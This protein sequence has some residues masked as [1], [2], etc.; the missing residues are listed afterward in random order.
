MASLRHTIA[1]VCWGH[2]E[3][4]AQSRMHSAG[5]LTRLSRFCM[6]T[7][8]PKLTA[9]ELLCLNCQHRGAMFDVTTM[10][11]NT[12]QAMS[13]IFSSFQVCASGV[14]GKIRTSG[15]LRCT[16][17]IHDGMPVTVSAAQPL[18]LLHAFVYCI[19]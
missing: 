9:P 18:I 1:L 6:K 19:P 10:K 8:I 12:I 17:R 3:T 2:F 11:Q 15:I 7:Q 16:C 5:V 14:E 13:A 4:L